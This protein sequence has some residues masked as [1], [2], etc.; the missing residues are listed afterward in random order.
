MDN[1][2]EHQFKSNNE[3]NFSEIPELANYFP[4]GPNNATHPANDLKKSTHIFAVDSR[5]RDFKFYPDANNY[6]ISIPNR[7]RNVTSIELKA[8]ILPRSEYNINNSNNTID[9]SISDHISEIKF[10]KFS[11]KKSNGQKYA[12]GDYP[13][14]IDEPINEGKKAEGIIKIDNY[15]TIID[16]IITNSGSGY[17]NKKIPKILN[18]E[19]RYTSNFN[20][21]VGINYNIKLRLGQYSIG[22]NPDLTEYQS[23]TPT[24]L[25]AEIESS[26]NYKLTN[27]LEYSYSRKSYNSYSSINHNK[28][29]PLL[30]NVRLM[31][32]YPNVNY[33]TENFTASSPNDFPS[34]SCLFNRIYINNS[35][36]FRGK[37]IPEDILNGQKSFFDSNDIEYTVI[38]NIKIDD[39][40][41][42]MC[43]IKDSL[44]WK[45][46]QDLS[47]GLIPGWKDSVFELNYCPYE[48]LFADGQYN[49]IN[50]A[51][52]LGFQKINYTD[53]TLIK[54][55]NTSNDKVLLPKGLVYSSK[56]DYF[57][58][59]DPEYLTLSFK[60]K[61]GGESFIGINDRVDSNPNSNIDRVFA[62]IIF[63]SIFPNN[64]QELSSGNTINSTDSYGINNQK[65][66]YISFDFDDSNNKLLTGGLG[67]QNSTFYR[68]PGMIRASK[69]ADFDKKIIEFIQPIAQISHMNIRFTKFS[70]G[71]FLN[72]EDE[73]YDFQGKEHLLLFEIVCA[74]LQTGLRF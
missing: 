47:V 54:N 49:Y 35:L 37:N 31:N 55:I 67:N 12:S 10:S 20:V 46:L 9:L 29:Y 8:A 68:P 1:F 39:S 65:K 62:C 52:L 57:L 18:F 66:S 59:S 60:P 7:Y 74:D 40:Y 5:Q 17:S 4:I 43:K 56:Y 11:V 72:S 36:M 50:S 13:L 38:K 44:N 71:E 63:D 33:Y 25:L 19:G 15:S 32:Q 70:Q 42:I 6:D 26:I 58:Y 64:N 45:G 22:G 30:F 3:N 53:P 23:W 24:G 21:K 27:D 48:I 41:I 61:Y 2:Y 28:D 73:L 69:G 34:N 51:S 14:E 16:I